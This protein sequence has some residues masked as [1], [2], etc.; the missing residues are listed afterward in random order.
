MRTMRSTVDLEDG[1]TEV[2]MSSDS[3]SRSAAKAS[4]DRTARRRAPRA[5]GAPRRARAPPPGP[6]APPPPARAPRRARLSRLRARTAATGVRRASP[7]RPPP[8]GR[9]AARPWPRGSM[10]KG[11]RTEFYTGT[12]LVSQIDKLRYALDRALPLE[13]HMR[14]PPP[15][16]G[17]GP[18]SGSAPVVVCGYMSVRVSRPRARVSRDVGGWS[19]PP[20]F[21]RAH[22]QRWR[23]DVPGF[24]FY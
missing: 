12:C 24:Q 23:L 9:G 4:A 17:S 6:A 8:G 10:G 22:P 14:Q 18:T 5:R 3:R 16:S 21:V 1:G 7:A 15:R 2:R 13:T 19:Q 11:A 20:A